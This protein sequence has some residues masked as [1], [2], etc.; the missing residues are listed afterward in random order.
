MLVVPKITI[1]GATTKKKK[2][3]KVPKT[4]NCLYLCITS[5]PLTKMMFYFLE[6]KSRGSLG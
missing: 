6:K 3:P 2:L 1:F 4:K 5:D